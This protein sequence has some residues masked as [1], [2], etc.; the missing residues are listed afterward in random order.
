MHPAYSVIVFTTLSGT[1]Y[2]LAAFLC[3]GMLPPS[4]AGG[5]IGFA[6]AGVMI[7]GGLISSTFHLRHPERAWRA[8]SQ[9]RSSWLSREGVLAIVFFVPFGLAGLG[10]T[11]FDALW[12]VPAG[13]T[14]FLAL[15]TVFATSMIY[16]SLKSVHA[17]YTPLTSLTYVGFAASGGG[18]VFL[19]LG[20]FLG[21]LPVWMP[22]LV[23][24]VLAFAWAAKGLWWW[25]TARESSASTPESATGLGDFGPTRLLDPPHSEA[26]YLMREMGYAVGRRHAAK[27]KLVALGFGLV[28]PLLAIRLGMTTAPAG[29]ALLAALSHYVGL[30]VERWLF[31]AE[32]RHTVMLYYGRAAA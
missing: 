16:A 22:N 12:T 5:L 11:F 6:L 23:M 3:L 4:L 21:G 8:F 27:L 20:A 19:T 25:R 10:F 32:A 2:G 26:N 13:L 17:W 29:F 14:V 18:L 7:A 30:L 24:I 15:A 28:V 31:F 9:W 1:G